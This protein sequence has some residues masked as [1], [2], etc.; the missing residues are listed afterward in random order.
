MRIIE[1][2]ELAELLGVSHWDWYRA[3]SPAI[4]SPPHSSTNVRRCAIRPIQRFSAV[5]PS[6]SIPAKADV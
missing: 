5:G 6:G 4:W 1:D 2:A 3:D